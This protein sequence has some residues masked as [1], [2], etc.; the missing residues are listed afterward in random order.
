MGILKSKSHLVKIP[1]YLYLPLTPQIRIAFKWCR[2]SAFGLTCKKKDILL[3]KW[4]DDA[5]VMA[6]ILSDF[7]LYAFGSWFHSIRFDSNHFN[8]ESDAFQ[9]ATA[10]DMQIYLLLTCKHTIL[11]QFVSMNASEEKKTIITNAIQTRCPVL[12]GW[13]S[14]RTYFTN[15]FHLEHFGHDFDVSLI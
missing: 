9:H 8:F 12:V 4:F 6:L 1:W 2:C 14:N 3:F 5:K 11:H 15:A 10:I 13:L 7:R